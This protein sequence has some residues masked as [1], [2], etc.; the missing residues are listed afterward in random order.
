MLSHPEGLGG[1]PS[2]RGE[3]HTLRFRHDLQFIDSRGSLLMRRVGRRS[4]LTWGRTMAVSG[5]RGS[6]D[7][8]PESKAWAMVSGRSSQ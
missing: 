3:P 6:G 2:D 7:T 4:M 5:M 8:A 1:F